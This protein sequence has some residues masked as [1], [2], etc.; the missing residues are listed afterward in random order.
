MVTGL[1]LAVLTGLSWVVTGAVVG[2]VE[3]HGRPTGQ[4]LA[5]RSA[6]L[7]AASLLLLA[8]G[9]IWWPEAGLFKLCLAWRP[10][11]LMAAWGSL[12]YVMAVFMGC[13]MSRGPNG[14]SWTIVQS[15]FVF[16]FAM[17]IALG[18]TSATPTR[19]TGL[20]LVLAGV[21]FGGLAKTSKATG[22]ASSVGRH[23]SSRGRAAPR[24]AWLVP[25]LLG[26]VFCGANQCAVNLVSF[27]PPDARP[28]QPERIV[29]GAL[30]M[31]SAAVLHG[32][33]AAARGATTPRPESGTAP[34]SF[35]IKVA[36][37]E[38]AVWL[39]AGLF[40]LYNALDL[41]QAAN[42]AAI[43]SPIMVASCIVG[44]LIYGAIALRERTNRHQTMGIVCSLVG[45][46]LLAMP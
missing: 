32:I 44:F 20:A 5:T 15:G 28:A 33:V 14:A 26:F 17:G 11:L 2:L 31:L 18:N 27:L 3:R 39:F 42:L 9:R 10:A 45:I 36:A 43:A 25:A 35:L 12:S 34:L 30:G 29:W 1:V 38:A 37:V 23:S 21:V 6:F 40:L 13:A 16:P 22:G 46:A 24:R 7:L 4:L 19:L 41:L 8:A